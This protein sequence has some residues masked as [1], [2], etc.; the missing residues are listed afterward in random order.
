MLSKAKNFMLLLG[1]TSIFILLW[2]ASSYATTGIVNTETLKLRKA[3]STSSEILDLLDYNEKLEITGEEGEWYSVVHEGT[4]GYV[5]KQY[6]RV[7]E[8]EETQTNTQ[9]NETV[10]TT[11]AENVLENTTTNTT[12]ETTSAEVT[13]PE[14]TTTPTQN[15][16]KEDTQISILPL[17]Q[18]SKI[19]TEKKGTSVEIITTAGNWCYIA[20]ENLNGWVRQDALESGETQT[21]TTAP[22]ETLPT[23]EETPATTEQETAIE[24]TTMYVT[25]SSVYVRS[26]PGTNYEIVTSLIRGN[27]VKA[28]AETSQWYK[29]EVNGQT[30]YISKSLVSTTRPETTSRGTETSRTQD[31]EKQV[32]TPEEE[33]TQAEQTV[34]QTSTGQQIV[35]YAKNYLGCKYVYGGSGPN[36]FDCSGFTM[37]VY[38][39]FGV[40]LSHSARAQSKVG[41]AV[42]KENL[43]LGDLVFFKDYETMDGI[44]H[45]GIYIGDG[46]FI[47]ASSGTGYC[48]KISTLLSGSYATRYETARRVI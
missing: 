4:A 23:T 37:Y 18:G 32:S 5:S 17:I 41:T 2:T 6:M 10:A 43:Q 48:V 33:N 26:G 11:E 44:G 19:G 30:G 28:V 22:Q 39:K 42:E 24:E 29:V 12:T 35:D 15:V 27:S 38:Q 1:M 45:C 9:V 13:Q 16:L 25:G 36:T 34:V 7:E 46:N 21:T 8:E 40:T 14:E 3:P 20:T 31:E 47:H